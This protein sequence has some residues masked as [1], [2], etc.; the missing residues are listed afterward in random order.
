ML[1]HG[2]PQLF[3]IQLSH[4]KHLLHHG[5]FAGH[6]LVATADRGGHAQLQRL[7]ATTHA[8]DHGWCDGL[9]PLLLGQTLQPGNQ[10]INVRAVGNDDPA[11]ISNKP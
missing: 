5:S 1:L 4:H 3:R 9:N 7:A 11:Q 2:G 10:S 6:Q 8:A